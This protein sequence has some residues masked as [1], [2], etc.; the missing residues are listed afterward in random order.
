MVAARGLRNKNGVLDDGWQLRL[1][2]AQKLQGGV[3]VGVHGIAGYTLKALLS[4]PVLF[5]KHI[6]KPVSLRCCVFSGQK[7]A[8]SGRKNKLDF[9]PNLWS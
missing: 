5:G 4:S 7:F 1:A 3:E 2:R 9:R 6:N 8:L